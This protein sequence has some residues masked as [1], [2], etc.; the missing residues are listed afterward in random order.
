MDETI[1][2]RSGADAPSGCQPA[3][4][5]GKPSS[6][7]GIPNA[8]LLNLASECEAA[9]ARDRRDL[10]KAAYSLV[11]GGPECIPIDR[12]PGYKSPRWDRFHA[13]LNAEAFECAAKMLVDPRALW[14][15]G[16]MEEGPFAR[17]CWPMPCG[18]FVGGY[19][20]GQAD[21]VDLSL[22]A[23]ALRGHAI[24]TEARRAGTVKQGPVHE[25]AAIAKKEQP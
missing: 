19:V 6:R 12:W 21:T 2:G 25:G 8:A 16:S 3:A 13:M 15:V 17:L 4:S 23:A 20:E 7:S 22:C 11:F 5:A 18:G 1:D 14:A 24:A 9:E 10:L